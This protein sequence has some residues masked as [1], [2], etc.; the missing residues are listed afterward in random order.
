MAAILLISVTALAQS[1]A[2][3]ANGGEPFWSLEIAG[4]RMTYSRDGEEISVPAPRLRTGADGRIRYVTRR[5]VVEIR[6]EPCEDEAERVYDDTV[7]VTANGVTVEGCGGAEQPPDSLVDTS[8]TIVAIAGEAVA[9]D[10]YAISFGPDALVGYAGCNRFSGSYSR[11]GDTLT[12][13][14]IRATRRACPEPRMSRERRA[15]QILGGPVTI[16][17]ADGETLLLSGDGGTIRLRRS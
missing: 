2:Y 10:N 5:L 12:L 8:W 16:S 13:G 1:G 4:G 11:N 3:R 17:F 9:G 14:A 15:W 6:P 7:R